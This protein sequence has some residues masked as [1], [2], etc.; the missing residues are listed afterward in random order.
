MKRWLA[1]SSFRS[2]LRNASMLLS[3]K[4]GGAVL[5][6]IALAFA[7]RALTPELFGTLGIIHAYAAGVSALAKFQTWQLIVRY[8]APALAKKDIDNFRDI[9]GL[10][11]GLDL[12][13]SAV[14]VIAGM[15]LLPFIGDWVG[16]HPSE[17]KLGFLYCTLIPFMT[18]ATPTGILRTLDKF[19]HIATKQL[20]T[21]LVRLAGAALS[22]YCG[23]GFAGFVITWYIAELIGGLI[24]WYYAVRE[25]HRENIRGALRPGLLAP[26]RR[27]EGAWSFVWTTNIQHSIWSAWSPATNVVIGG[28]LG[29]AAAGLFKIAMT[30]FNA[31]GKPANLLEK[32]FYPEIMRLDPTSKHPW[33]LAIRSGAMAGG[34]SLI[35]LLLVHLG[36]E[37]LIRLAFGEKY[38]EAYGL[39]RIMTFS[40]FISMATFPLGSLLYM[41][42]RHRAALVAEGLAVL[43]YGILLVVLIHQFGLIGAGFA[44][45]AGM[46]MKALF[47]LIPTVSSYN[48]RHLLSHHEEAM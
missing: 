38:V 36:G 11:F 16:I 7:G 34:L 29:P 22:F 13:S 1:D 14:G 10:S 47:A 40:L 46:F 42:G 15:A 3:G 23:F 8:G 5:G 4:L 41:A 30:F 6:L 21:P 17:L 27:I 12:A 35:V 19:A 26:A 37:P 2:I 24:L 43:G 48:K 33:K 28:M 20:V 25:L 9:T 39:L 18:A 45:V 31:A 44:Y 32:S